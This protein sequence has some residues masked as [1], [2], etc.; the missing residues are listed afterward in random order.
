M[1]GFQIFDQTVFEKAVAAQQAAEQGSPMTLD[2]AK[3]RM[4]LS[5]NTLSE[6]EEKANMPAGALQQTIEGYNHFVTSGTDLDFGRQALAGKYG[7]PQRIEKP[8]FYAFA[9]IGHLLATYGG[10]AVDKK[11]QVLRNG[12]PIPGLYA[13]GEAI[14]GFHGASYHS[15]TAI[16]KALVF[17]RLSG[18][19]AALNKH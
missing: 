1:M 15:G 9:T 5:G 7:L 2:A 3:I 6:L 11:M 12:I 13:A 10:I 16:G 8:P 18:K 19:N 14:G 17:G 4:L